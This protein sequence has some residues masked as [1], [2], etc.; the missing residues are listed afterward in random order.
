MWKEFTSLLEAV[1][2]WAFL[3]MLSSQG[4][5][6]LSFTFLWKLGKPITWLSTWH[7]LTCISFQEY[8]EQKWTL[9]YSTALHY[10]EIPGS[11]KRQSMYV[12]VICTGRK[13]FPYLEGKIMA[14]LGK[15]WQ[16][17]HHHKPHTY[18]QT[19]KTRHKNP[20][21]RRAPSVPCGLKSPCQR[22]LF[23]P[24][25]PCFAPAWQTSCPSM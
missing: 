21:G 11:S 19:S 5:K 16:Q 17:Q 14:V 6:S 20:H 22:S 8:G 10:P 23:Y 9:P 2:V 24:V 3:I 4:P 1:A 25:K 18:T 13:L 7:L 15:G 12:S